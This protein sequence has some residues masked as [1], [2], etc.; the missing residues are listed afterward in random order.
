MNLL[1]ALQTKVEIEKS[2]LDKEIQQSSLDKSSCYITMLTIEINSLK[3][4]L[5]IAQQTINVNIN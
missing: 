1:E 2:I 3:Y 5:S 4:V